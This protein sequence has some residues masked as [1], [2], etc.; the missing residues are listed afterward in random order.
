MR[1]VTY[2]LP[3]HHAFPPAF[4]TCLTFSSLSCFSFAFRFL[5]LVSPCVLCPSGELYKYS[6]VMLPCPLYLSLSAC[7]VLPFLAILV[8]LLNSYSFSSSLPSVPPVSS[9]NL[10]LPSSPALSLYLFLPAI[11]CF[12]FYLYLRPRRQLN[13]KEQYKKNSN[14]AHD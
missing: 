7:P 1:L 5:L 12:S 8:L 3:P 14:K 13:G 2:T 6:S 10:S 9:T 11:S 4:P